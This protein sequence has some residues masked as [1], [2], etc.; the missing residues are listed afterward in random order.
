MAALLQGFERDIAHAALARR[1]ILTIQEITIEERLVDRLARI[2]ESRDL[3]R[4]HEL[5]VRARHGPLH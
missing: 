3:A 2:V 4:Q 1:A 5:N